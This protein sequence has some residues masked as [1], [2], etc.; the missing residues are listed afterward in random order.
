MKAFPVGV[1]LLFLFNACSSSIHIEKR[2]HNPGFYVSV[3]NDRGSI[4]AESV[5]SED[6]EE[7]EG[8]K[9]DPAIQIRELKVEGVSETFE[10][11][12]AEILA[13]EIS[14][15]DQLKGL[16]LTRSEDNARAGEVALPE[17][18]NN[19]PEWLKPPEVAPR[20]EQ[21][22]SVQFSGNNVA[23]EWIIAIVIIAVVWFLLEILRIVLRFRWLVRIVL[24]MLILY[25]FFNLI[26]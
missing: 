3:S 19:F 11:L 9:Y 4:S 14:F 1:L 18:R 23:A 8:G 12:R 26:G 20:S 25:F 22:I 16:M 2:Q 15:P 5:K 6:I 24:T 17:F 10:A 21:N 7:S 13:P